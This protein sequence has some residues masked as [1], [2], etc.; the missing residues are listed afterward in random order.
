MKSSGLKKDTEFSS[1]ALK[2]CNPLTKGKVFTGSQAKFKT[3][4][5]EKADFYGIHAQ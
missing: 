5:S 3:R 4:D 2:L 1:I